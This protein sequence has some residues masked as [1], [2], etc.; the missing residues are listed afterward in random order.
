MDAEGKLV[1]GDAVLEV[2]RIRGIDSPSPSSS[3]MRS[4]PVGVFADEGGAG[5][6]FPSFRV[7]P[8]FSKY[9]VR[10]LT[11]EGCNIPP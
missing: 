8:T 4:S 11:G 9:S 10:D 5:E 2:G 6:T 3:P 7:V 1:P